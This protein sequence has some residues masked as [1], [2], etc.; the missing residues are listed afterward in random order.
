[1]RLRIS[2][3]VA[4]AATGAAVAIAVAAPTASG[5][6]ARLAFSGDGSIFTMNA[7]GSGRAQLTHGFRSSFGP[8]VDDRP[9]WSPD[10]SVI[11]FDRYRYED[12]EYG[13]GLTI[14]FWAMRADGSRARRL[15][16]GDG[17]GAGIV[18]FTRRGEVLIERFEEGTGLTFTAVDPR[19][20][21]RRS[22]PHPPA[23]YYDPA[24]SPDRRWIAGGGARLTVTR[25]DGSHRRDFTRDAWQPSWSPD[26]ER[27]AFVS[28]KDHNGEWCTS[29]DSCDVSGEIYVIDR[30]G[31]NLRRLT[32][33]KADDRAPRWSPDGRRISF[34]SDRNSPQ[35]RNTE[36]YSIRPDGR[37]LT[38]LTNGSIQSGAPD[39]SPEGG[40]TSPGACGS[41]GREPALDLDLSPLDSV[42]YPV[43]WLGP[44]I[45]GGMIL[46]TIRVTD[47]LAALDWADCG[48]YTPRRCGRGASVINLPSCGFAAGVLRWSH[49][50]RLTKRRGVL[51]TAGG[52]VGS[53]PLAF[54]GRT[55][56]HVRRAAVVDGLRRYPS[57]NRRALPEAAFPKWFY[58]ALRRTEDSYERTHSEGRTAHELAISRKDV[59]HR[60]TL[61][62]K[63]RELDVDRRQECPAPRAG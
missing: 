6:P 36:I 41:A 21:S 32:R 58:K 40:N 53:G 55:A 37:C 33:S 34:Q 42:G 57:T 63:L 24:Y 47:E 39:W 12:P 50:E 14:E 45:A 62:K 10:G 25:A 19:T 8:T 46:S 2:W 11:A 35:L 13:Y 59:H 44:R 30:D 3:R 23:F 61:A 48:Y 26:G 7:D 27:I 60:L 28:E 5:A 20:G 31:G 9:R 18:G 22:V 15:L 52:F 43:Y 56:I 4:L 1:M 38:W 17:Y 51:L 54:S 49:P 16:T 29:E